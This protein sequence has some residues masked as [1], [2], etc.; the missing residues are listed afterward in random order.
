MHG[1]PHARMGKAPRK[2]REKEAVG[3]SARFGALFQGIWRRANGVQATTLPAGVPVPT[4]ATVLEKV[5]DAKIF[6]K[7]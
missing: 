2:I 4:L 6:G 1:K 7:A 3:W 5:T